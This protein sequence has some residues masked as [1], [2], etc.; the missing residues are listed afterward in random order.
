MKVIWTFHL[1][2]FRW[3]SKVVYW[4]FTQ[5]VHFTTK[6]S[7]FQY[8]SVESM[9]SVQRKNW[10]SSSSSFKI[11]NSTNFQFILPFSLLFGE[12]PSALI[13]RAPVLHGVEV[14]MFSCNVKLSVGVYFLPA[15]S[16]Y[17]EGES[18]IAWIFLIFLSWRINGFGLMASIR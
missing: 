10:L 12:F 11:N 6:V 3:K 5:H 16:S 17:I 18:I 1:W 7:L 8:K 15:C 4:I 14:F 2:L 13:I 9:Y